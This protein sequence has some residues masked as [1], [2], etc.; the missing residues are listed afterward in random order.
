MFPR[1]SSLAPSIANCCGDFRHSDRCSLVQHN[2]RVSATTCDADGGE[3]RRKCLALAGYVNILDALDRPG[4]VEVQHLFALVGVAC[5]LVLNVVCEHDGD[6]ALDEW[7]NLTL[8]AERIE[9]LPAQTL[10]S[11]YELQIA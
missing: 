3:E 8:K 9:I 1:L 5:A 2:V 4:S 7:P 6:L 10:D 11:R